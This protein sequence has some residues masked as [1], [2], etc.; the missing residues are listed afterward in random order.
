V[1]VEV[2]GSAGADFAAVYTGFTPMA[3]SNPI[4][5]DADGNGEWTAPGLSAK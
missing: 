4:W 1:T 3:F 5:V 2:E